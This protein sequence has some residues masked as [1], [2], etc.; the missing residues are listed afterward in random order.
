MC[1]ICGFVQVGGQRKKRPGVLNR[2][3]EAIRH[4]G[5]DDEGSY[6][7]DSV[8]IGMRRL[9][10]IDPERGKQPI[11]NERNDIVLVFNGE[12]YNHLELRKWLAGRGHQFR[13][14]CDSEVVVHL[15]EELGEACIDRLRGMFGFSIWDRG[16]K[17]FFMARDR[18]GIKPLYYTQVGESLVFASE[19]KS[20]LQFPGVER[21]LDLPA[22]SNF[23]SLRYVPAPQTMFAGIHALPPGHRMSVDT[24]GVNID[25][26]WDLRYEPAAPTDRSDESF[27]EELG[28]LLQEAVRM[29]LMSDVPFGAFL[30]GGVDSSLIV[31]LMSEMLTEP[32]KTFSIGFHEPTPRFSELPFART[33]AEQYQTDH[34]DV[35]VRPEDLND[36]LETVVWHLDQPVA[37]DAALANY[38]VAEYASRKVK[39]VLGGEG[40]DELFAGYARYEGE[41]FA[42]MFG[43]T[44]RFFKS[45]ALKIADRLPGL[46]RPKIALFA[47]SQADEASRFV[48][49]FPLFND[50]TKANLLTDD[51]AEQL[52]AYATRD[53]FG[54]HLKHVDATHSLNRL[55]YVDTKLWLPDVL[56]ARGDKMSM[57]ASLE[58]RVP[59]LDH[60]L[61]EFACQLPP[62][63]KLN[64]LTR[65]YLLKKVSRRWLPDRIVDRKKQGFPTP[66]FEWF[67]NQARALVR[68][69]LS[70]EAIHRR[71]LFKPAKAQQLLDEHESGF[72]DHGLLIW[73]LLNIELWQQLFLDDAQLS[74]PSRAATNQVA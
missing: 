49:W 4:R 67:R 39:M 5:P 11:F 42:P 53:V 57:A 63:L 8:S 16:K 18:L 40:S 28:E 47:L 61:V 70:P 12:I 72:A 35:Y 71:G 22:L 14:D 38:I 19:I 9:S 1:G 20:L 60:K 52:G 51:V 54:E 31:A 15:Y 69:V 24:G 43:K 29:R 66:I 73:G 13:S 65:K 32:V 41:Q 68:D 6:C 25:R 2:M 46:R 21:R 58:V 50:Q 17:R 36:H 33:V 56:L 10:I 45:A 34:H 26:Y 3:L 74:A 37:D 55:L 62:R 30:S 59:F 48:N 27:A 7:D 44:P 23:L 64:R